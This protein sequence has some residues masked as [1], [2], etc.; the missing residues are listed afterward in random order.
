M[1]SPQTEGKW[2][3]RFMY[4]MLVVL[5]DVGLTVQNLLTKLYQ[6]R[7]GDGMEAGMLFNALLGG[8]G[9]LIFFV[10]EG[11]RMEFTWYSLLMG[12]LIA[13]CSVIYTVIGF[14]I[15]AMGYVAVYSLFLMLGVMILPYLFGVLFLN[16]PASP[17]RWVGLVLLVVSIALSGGVENVKGGSSRTYLLLCVLVFLLN[18]VL[19]ILSKLHQIETVQPTI[20]DIS[21]VTLN[22]LI[23]LVLCGS[24]YLV[25]RLRRRRQYAAAAADPE[26]K[27]KISWKSMLLLV[28]IV[29]LT[30]AVSGAAYLLQLI[31]NTHLPASVMYPIL[32]GGTIV[33]TAVAGLLVYRERLSRKGWIGIA[34]CFGATLL[35]L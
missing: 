29:F 27:E 1:R 34:L 13:L 7:A 15:M 19:G 5:A 28:G 26:Q 22:G 35:F 11:F 20:S 24:C 33:I 10:A 14:K 9:A 23:K 3:K 17:L 32:T 31:G 6:K 25:L 30:A 16:E 8:F 18:G 4:E 2:V 12:V 21:F